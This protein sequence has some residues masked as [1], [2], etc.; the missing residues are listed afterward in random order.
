MKAV[1]VAVRDASGLGDH[2]TGVQQA[3]KPDGGPLTD[4]TALCVER[5]A[6]KNLL[7]GAFGAF[8][9]PAGHAERS[10]KKAA[11]RSPRE[12]FGVGVCGV[13]VGCVAG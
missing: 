1:E 12:G 11:Q 6:T 10:A 4:T 13:W 3:F 7:A 5:V 9:N 2:L 8:R